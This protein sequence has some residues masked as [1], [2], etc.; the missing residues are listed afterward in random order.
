MVARGGQ[1]DFGETNKDPQHCTFHINTGHN[2][3]SNS[4]PSHSPPVLY[5]SCPV[6]VPLPSC[7]GAVWSLVPKQ[8]H[9]QF[10]MVFSCRALHEGGGRVSLCFPTIKCFILIIVI[11]IVAVE[12]LLGG[13]HDKFMASPGLIRLPSNGISRFKPQL[14]SIVQ[15]CH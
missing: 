14:C 12:S 9:R 13:R 3:G 6:L 11:A 7:S 5:P 4:H 10:L 8:Q 15:Q 2:F 1:R